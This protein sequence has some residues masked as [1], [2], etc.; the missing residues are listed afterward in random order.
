MS[1][2]FCWLL[3]LLGSITASSAD[4]WE[5]NVDNGFGLCWFWVGSDMGGVISANFP[6][7]GNI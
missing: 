7:L 5:G 2:F 6:T 1:T 3:L 4:D